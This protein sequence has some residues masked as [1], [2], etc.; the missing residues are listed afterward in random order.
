VRTQL[1]LVA[2]LFPI[3]ALLFPTPAGAQWRYP[4]GYPG[5]PAYRYAQPESH[6]R[7]QVKPSDA[8][9]Y[10]D[11]FFAGKVSEFDGR[12]QRLH[13]LPGQHEIVI[14]LEGYRSLK[15]Q[16]YLSPDS[17]R[18]IEGSLERLA[19]GEIQDPQPVPADRD[20]LEPGD[21]EQPPLPQRPV[22]RR[23][24][25]PQR[26]E[27][28]PER[29][30]SPQGE[31]S[32]YATLSI[33]V[34]PGGGVVRIDGERWDAPTGDERLIVQVTEGRHVV[35]VERDGYERFSTEVDARRGETLPVTISL[36]RR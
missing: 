33:Q 30:R 4:P 20:R 6:L 32:R 23:G 10:V 15:R 11:G 24:G 26:P 16:L 27:P 18:T 29:P 34:R 7:I 19:A 8:S 31:V 3:T 36:R 35:E 17:T 14:Y 28:P 21:E 25:P 5:Y 9:V 12:F 22:P 1:Q 13:V 2:L